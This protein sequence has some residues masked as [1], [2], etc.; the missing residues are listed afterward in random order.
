LDR[1]VDHRHV[2]APRR[3]GEEVT[4]GEVVR[5]VDDQVVFLQQ[6]FHVVGAQ[7]LVMQRDFYAWV[8]RGQGHARRFGFRHADA[9]IGMDHL[10]MQIGTLDA[11]VID[12]RELPYPGGGEIKRCR[13]TE[14]AG[15]QQYD[16][17]L[18]QLELAGLAQLRQAQLARVA[19]GGIDVELGGADRQ[20]FG[21]PA[22]ETAGDGCDL[23]VSHALQRL[24]GEQRA[25]AAPAQGEYFAFAVGFQAFDAQF[26]E[27]ARQRQRTGGRSG[28]AL[29]VFAYVDQQGALRLFAQGAGRSQ[30]RYA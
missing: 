17:G 21:F 14:A 5:A 7:A 12:Q 10:P 20:A 22:L 9:R 29:V 18:R 8:E 2:Q 26:E 25:N 4:R 24:G 15:A 11:V 3:C 6:A 30:L 28:G 27:A 1:A 13:R 19:F 23:A 16:A